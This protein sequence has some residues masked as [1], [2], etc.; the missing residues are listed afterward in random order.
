VTRSDK[1]SLESRPGSQARRPTRVLTRLG[2]RVGLALVIFLC[3]GAIALAQNTSASLEGVVRSQEGTPLKEAVVHARSESTGVVRTVTTGGDGRYRI[4][5]LAP[6]TWK[7]WTEIPG[8]LTSSPRTIVLQLQETVTLDF[9]I[10]AAATENVTVTASPPM[11]ERT[12]TGS[13]L[14]VEGDQA[15]DLPVDGRVVTD[16]ALLDSAIAATPPG[17][18]Y[19]ERGSV[20]V[21]N[22]QSGRSNTFLVDGLDNNDMTSGTT[23][24]ASFSQ[25]V[26]REFVVLTHQYS[27]EF[28]RASGGV[29]NIIT[30]RGTN[31]TEA[32]FFFQGAAEGL[33]ATGAFVSD[34]PS[35]D[36]LQDSSGRLATGFEIGGPIRKDK[37]FYLVA[38]EH[39]QEDRVTPYTGTDRN[40][41]A[42]GWTLAPNRDDNLFFRSDFNLGKSHYLMVRLS[43]DDR[44][45]SDLNVGGS[46]TPEAGFEVDE[47]DVQIAA[48]LTSV[49]SPTFFNE[50][51]LLI[52]TSN[53]DQVA[54]SDRPGVDRPSG[55]FGGNNLNQQNRDENK[56]EILDNLTWKAGRHTP[57]AGMDVTA[58]RTDIR[59]SFNPNGN[60]LYDTDLPFEP[61]DC[62]NLLVSMIDPNDPWAPIPCPGNPGV[63]DDGDGVIDEP[64]I[65]GTYPV[66]FQ[67]I[68]HHPSATL[69]DT[70]LALFAQ[71]SWQA[72]PHLVLDYGLR[73]DVSTYVLP[74]SATVPSKFENGGAGRD[75]NNVA[76]RF[77]FSWTPGDEGKTV[78]RGGGGIFYDKLVL[79]F[80]AVA[81]I[82]SGTEI[83]ILPAQGLTLEITEDLVEQVGIDQILP[84]LFF[85][86]EFILRFSTGTS[87]DTP[88][89]VQY[90]L[91]AD[92]GVGEHGV[93]TGSVTRALGYH[94]PLFKD[95]N[96]VRDPNTLLPYHLDPNT[97]SIAALVTEGRSWYTGLDLGWRYRAGARWFGVGYTWS[98]AIDM[99]PDPLKGGVYLPPPVY[100][101]G[102]RP[103][104][105]LVHE[106][107]RSD[108]DRRHRM[109]FS[110]SSDLPWLG[111]RI[112]GVVQVSTGV[113]FNVTSGQDEDNNGI[114]TDR[115][116]G[117][118]RNSGDRTDLDAVN[119]LRRNAPVPLPAV[120][121]L[122]EPYFAQMDVRLGRPFTMR[123]GKGMGE[124]FVQV[125][126][127]FNRFN[128][129]PIDGVATSRTFGEPVGQTGPPRTIEF[130]VKLRMQPKAAVS[131]AEGAGGS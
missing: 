74:S 117:V 67:Y 115:P 72:T 79:G 42:G 14:R 97:G 60:F 93:F 102:R 80:P 85:P 112:S 108:S 51:R 57:K 40:G 43:A 92:Q 53:F 87:L 6:G 49:I 26:I 88:Y 35:Q 1:G 73:Y 123:A 37:A 41:V 83:G 76:P 63:D 125:F 39:N 90:S 59:T 103:D 13:V 47:T 127:V 55:I 15:D 77:G 38:Y 30:D 71:D 62:G 34:L 56:I 17:N 50:T 10:E 58:S 44:T 91:G 124:L 64:G 32:E 119:D 7:V 99:G 131:P 107:G 65:I 66:V 22:G 21:V 96:P 116:K 86:D 75:V 33:N 8:G 101:P 19:G 52:G 109:V 20:F 3:G 130:G 95:L 78:L 27:P 69:D 11:V 31:D 46:A 121:S 45:T 105:S 61:G 9:A 126:N 18:F 23:L 29:L 54:N 5:P 68:K 128:G 100:R 36:G 111:L 122:E 106:Q 12:R 24:N 129:G 104:T 114:S 48:S 25:Q 70:R 28:G 120:D 89:T 81:S 82:T 118:P 110:G 2:L 4:A 84:L 16:L 98:K 94:L 113:P